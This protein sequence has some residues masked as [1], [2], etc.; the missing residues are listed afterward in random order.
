MPMPKAKTLVLLISVFLAVLLT[1]RIVLLLSSRPRIAVDY[2]AQLN[3]LSRPAEYDSD[4]NAAPFYQLA[5]D[6]FVEPPEELPMLDYADRPGDFNDAEQ[7][8]LRSWFASNERALGYF[9]EATTRPYYWLERHSE[10]D[11]MITGIP[12][13]ELS[14]LN[15]LAKA[16]VWAAKFEA[17][18]GRPEVAWQYILDCYRAGG[19][20][21]SANLLIMEQHF[22]LGLREQSVRG[23]A[24]IL[25][26]SRV[27]TAVLKR[28]Q[29][30]LQQELDSDTYIP[31]AAAERLED[32]D[33]LQLAFVHHSKGTGRLWWRACRGVVILSTGEDARRMERQFRWS[34]ILGPTR[35]EAAEQ[36]ER[37][38]SLFNQLVDKTPWQIKSGS[39]DY[40]RQVRA[41]NTRHAA[42]EIM[43]IG[44]DPEPLLH[45][46]HKTR[47]QTDALIA[48]LAILRYKADHAQLPESL[49]VLSAGGYL[50]AVPED[51][52]SGAPLVYR[53][54]DDGFQL[55][56]IGPNFTDDNGASGLDI[57]CWPVEKPKD[58]SQI[59]GD[60]YSGTPKANW[61]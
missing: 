54:A 47:L 46:Y 3:E 2:V 17:A 60:F 45:A 34:W 25:D 61:Q 53:L 50:Q 24:V 16:V 21:C 59:P 35:N 33:A 44:I 42:L 20:K 37:T 39:V 27:G 6:A 12:Y 32:Y 14:P 41:I 4:R 23:A 29:D 9:H 55:Y 52:Y 13:R 48:V 8:L 49:D 51:P 38:F 18:Q 30:D 31:G 5:F 43:R 11:N 1:A 58:P 36:I 56:S 40:F 10:R 7:A 57:V 19:H 26:S 15:Q 28:L 22:G